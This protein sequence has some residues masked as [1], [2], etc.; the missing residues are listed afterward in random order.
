MNASTKIND[1][2]DHILHINESGLH[3]DDLLASIYC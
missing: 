1:S 3:G 2:N